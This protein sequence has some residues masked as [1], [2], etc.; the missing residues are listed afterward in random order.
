MV[1]DL[2]LSPPTP[3]DSSVESGTSNSSV[4]EEGGGFVTREL[5]PQSKGLGL[6]QDAS[7]SSSSSSSLVDL[8]FGGCDFRPPPPPSQQ[9][10]MMKR[11]RRGPRS[12]SSQYRGVTFYRRTGR[13]ESHICLTRLCFPHLFPHLSSRDTRKQVYLGGFDTA[14]AAARAYDRAAIKFR[15]VEADINFNL[16]DYEDDLKQMKNLTKEEFVHVLRRQSNGFARGSSKYRGVTCHKCGHWAARMGQFLG[17]K[18]IYLGLFNSEV[19]AARAYDK[20][21]I[22]SNGREA[23]TNFTNFDPSTY[24]GEILPETDDNVVCSD[25]VSSLNL[26][27]DLKISQ[28]DIYSPNKNDNSLGIQFNS[29]SLEASDAWNAKVGNPVTHL[30]VYPS[31]LAT[32]PM[33]SRVWSAPYPGFFPIDEER[34]TKKRPEWGMQALPNWAWQMHGRAPLP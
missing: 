9:Q 19:E 5:F 25:L 3:R 29:G 23:V 32:A 16:N 17:K 11:T 34:A 8:S 28:C 2:N 24:D 27:L 12:R 30:D 26:D 22:K 20:A 18:Y 1:L 13:W 10:Q 15:G 33:E 6:V 7:S 21:A 31:S 4:D 14:Y